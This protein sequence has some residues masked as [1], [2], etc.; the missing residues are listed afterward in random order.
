MNKSRILLNFLWQ[1]AGGGVQ[2][3]LSFIETLSTV[4]DTGKFHVI[5]RKDS[6]I[7]RKAMGLGYSC[8]QIKGNGPAR[9]RFS[10][11]CKSE[12]EKEQLCFTFFGPPLLGACGNL[13]NICGVAYSWLYYPEI[14]FWKHYRGPL[15]WKKEIK[16]RSKMY[17]LSFAD[18]WIFETRTLA[19]RAIELANYPAERVGVV[20]MTPSLLVRPERVKQGAARIF[21]QSIPKGFRFLFLAMATSNKRI[22]HAAAIAA[23]LKKITD[24]P[25]SIVTT[26]S[27]ESAYYKKVS[28]AFNKHKVSEHLC[29]LGPC[30]YDQAAC[31][32]E[33]C[34]C[35]CL[36]SVLESFSNNF[37][38]AWQMRKP[39][40]ATDKD[41][42]RS[43]AGQAALY[44]DPEQPEATARSL[45]QLI[46]DENRRRTLVQNGV[47]ALKNYPTAEQKCKQYL[48][49]IQKAYTLGKLNKQDRKKIERYSCSRRILK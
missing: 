18:Y 15:R 4:A 6:N 1:G 39:L 19:Q 25:F 5:A 26:M 17:A 46:E 2:N 12:F 27:T 13:I 42:S 33:V 36:F 31:L 9:Y 24:K 22:H 16:A 44:V 40:V 37:V 23:E 29:N 14:T 48:E 3:A 20:R 47:D 21:D 8:M 10:M 35:M 28:Q 43:V 45:A 38:E 30:P 34:D 32:I 11:F 7:A 41:W 49:C